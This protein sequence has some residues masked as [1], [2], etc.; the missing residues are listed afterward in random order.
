MRPQLA[1]QKWPRGVDRAE[2]DEERQGRIKPTLGQVR[3][4]VDR[5]ERERERGGYV[6]HA[7]ALRLGWLKCPR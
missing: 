5:Q 4:R 2:Q 7:T 6:Q 1:Q 3:E